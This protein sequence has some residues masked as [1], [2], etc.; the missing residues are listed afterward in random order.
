M[1]RRSPLLDV[2]WHGLK[3]DAIWQISERGTRVALGFGLAIV[4][5]RTLGPEDFGVYSY[6]QSV[7][8]LF[9]FLAQAGLDALLLRELIRA[10]SDAPQFLAAGFALRAL[11]ALV[12]AFSAIALAILASDADTHA[13]TPVVFVLTLV[14]MAQ[15]GW[16]AESWLQANSR[17]SSAARAKICAYLLGALLRLASLLSPMPLLALASAAVI[18]AL[19]A[20]ILLWRASRIQLAIGLRDLQAPKWAQTLALGRLASALILSACTVALYSRIDVF[21]LGKMLGNTSAGLYSAGTMIS[22]GFYLFPTAI[23]IAV[24][25]RLARQYLSDKVEFEKSVHLIIRLLSACGLVIA[26][27]LTV[28]AQYI[29]PLIFGNDYADAS[30]VL[31]IH[32]WSTWAVF[33]SSASD[34][35]Y[36]NH[37]L[38]KFYLMKTASAA[39]LN[40][41]LNLAFIPVWGTAGAAAATVISYVASALLVGAA[42]EATRPLFLLQVRAISGRSPRMYVGV[43]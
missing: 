23:M 40:V 9:A 6:A 34:P 33:V 11:G 42:S 27:V 5:A 3:S 39:I 4:V 36:I 20:S 21:M 16:V 15:A 38:R 28:A 29:V 13:A 12:A 2:D 22:E 18:E 43:N 41:L 19:V 37:D 26:A 1:P 10:P 17:F 35:W 30:I 25:P 8:L 14:G 7:V 24:A 32:I 31:Q